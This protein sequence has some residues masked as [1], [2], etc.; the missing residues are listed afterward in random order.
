[1]LRDPPFPDSKTNLHFLWDSLPGNFVSE[2]L[3]LYEA[4]GLATDP[5]YSRE[6]M[7]DQL[8]VGDF[9]AWANE[10]HE[11]AKKHVYYFGGSEITFGKA[12]P[13]GPNDVTPGLPPGYL[14][15]AEKVAMRQ[16]T[17]AGHRLADLL[18]GIFDHPQ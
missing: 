2:D 4:K 18:N 9:M 14:Q 11:L 15:N 5:R 8:A 3:C 12:P 16:V 6:A 17:L 7:K 13:T 1:M 10:S